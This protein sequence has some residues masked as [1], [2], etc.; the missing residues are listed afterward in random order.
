MQGRKNPGDRVV[1]PARRK[2]V[3][4]GPEERV[5]QN[6][7]SLLVR[8]FGVPLG[9]IAVEK[10]IADSERSLRPDIVVHTRD[11][12]PWMVIECKAPNVELSQAAFDQIGLYN[13]I[14]QARYLFLTNGQSHFCCELNGENATVTYLD[15]LPEYPDRNENVTIPNASE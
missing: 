4:Q 13:R 10:Q 12:K 3:V 6:V 15:K 2:A 1:D 8:E 11:G 9:L 5:R 14:T 7:I